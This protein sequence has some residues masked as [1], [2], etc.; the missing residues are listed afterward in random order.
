MKIRNGFVSNSSSS[1]F[2]ISAHP[3][4]SLKTTITIE[5][6]INNYVKQTINTI[7][8][9]QEYL[10][11]VAG[12]C[13]ITKLKEYGWYDTYKKCLSAL[14][15]GN[16]IYVGEFGNENGDVIEN[17][18]LDNGLKDCENFK[19]IQSEAGY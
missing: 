5:A 2:I 10:E 14:E 13:S 3:K 11:D 18:L 15:Q 8:E 17:L 12:T 16:I 19:V 1:S 4:Q 6:N 7:E 9:L